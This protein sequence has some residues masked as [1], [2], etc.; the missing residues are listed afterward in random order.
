MDASRFCEIKLSIA[1]RLNPMHAKASAVA[2]GPKGI[3]LLMY[4]IVDLRR[5]QVNRRIHARESKHDSVQKD[6][7]Y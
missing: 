2:W 5:H 3:D 6:L 4:T 7:I 1:F